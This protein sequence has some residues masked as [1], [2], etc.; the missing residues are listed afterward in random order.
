MTGRTIDA[1]KRE[2]IITG[3]GG[4]GIVLA[5]QIL[6]KAAALGDHRHSTLIQSYGPEARG[7]ACSAQVII[8]EN[9]IHYPDVRRPNIL[10]C[11]SQSG[12][13]SFFGLLGLGGI[14]LVDQDLVQRS[15]IDRDFFSI[16]STRMAEDLE[17]KMVANIIMVGFLTAI[18]KAVSVDAA[19]NA[20]TSSVPKGSEDLNI[21]AFDKGCDYGLAVLRG[22]QKK[23]NAKRVA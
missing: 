21:T 19:R 22:Q 23:A 15:E 8:S 16:P 13:D 4:Q 17:K 2:I 11:M 7:G 14:L 10:V 18:T 6:G 20:V 12:F 3:F 9:P 1:A 5:G